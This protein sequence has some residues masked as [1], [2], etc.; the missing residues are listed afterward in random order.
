MI[1]V[2]T[3]SHS[4]MGDWLHPVSASC[5]NTYSVDALEGTP[6]SGKLAYT[7]KNHH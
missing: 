1:T 3:D 2:I 6:I 7:A 5:S 4:K